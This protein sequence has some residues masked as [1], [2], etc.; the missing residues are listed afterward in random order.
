MKNRTVEEIEGP[1]GY[2]PKY[3]HGGYPY[4]CEMVIALKDDLIK[5]KG[6]NILF[7]VKGQDEAN[8]I[9]NEL[10]KT[11]RQAQVDILESKE[12]EG[13][14]ETMRQHSKRKCP[15]E[16]HWINPCEYLDGIRKESLKALDNL[17]AKLKEKL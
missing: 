11:I 2:G 15:D 10:N 1:Y 8:R 16:T 4:D 14:K 13:L 7:V 17:K 5:F 9:V 6:R 3:L 12:V